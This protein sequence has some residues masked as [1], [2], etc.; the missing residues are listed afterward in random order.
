MRL[1]SLLLL[2]ELP[3]QDR[4]AFGEDEVEAAVTKRRQSKS[5]IYLAKLAS[6]VADPFPGGKSGK[7]VGM[8]LRAVRRRATHS[9]EARK[10]PKSPDKACCHAF[11]KKI[12]DD[13]NKGI[14]EFRDN[15]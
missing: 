12:R 10:A 5:K 13:P 14:V 2:T 11:T 7:D 9:A 4:R 15:Y 3:P 1:R 6:F 8:K